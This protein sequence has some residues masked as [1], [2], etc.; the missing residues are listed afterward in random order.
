MPRD[1][2]GRVDILVLDATSQ[3]LRWNAADAAMFRSAV[4]QQEEVLERMREQ[5]RAYEQRRQ[6]GTQ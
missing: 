5:L 6:A 3:T 1:H 4:E 2:G